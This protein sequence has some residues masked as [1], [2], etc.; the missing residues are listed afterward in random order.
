MRKHAVVWHPDCTMR[1]FVNAKDKEGDAGHQ[2][3]YGYLLDLGL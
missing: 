2:Q 3:C 1:L